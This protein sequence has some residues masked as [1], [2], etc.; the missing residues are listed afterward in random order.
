M[1]LTFPIRIYAD[2]QGAQALAKNPVFHGRSKHI[3]LTWHAQ[4]HMIDREQV[5][6]VHT[7]TKYQAA[8][9]FTKPL[10]KEKFERFKEFLK[11]E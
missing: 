6:M 10:N 4:K 2:N 9:G 3:S 7:L 11:L 8:D 1:P 5:E